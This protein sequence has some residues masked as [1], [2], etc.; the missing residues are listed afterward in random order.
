MDYVLCLYVG[1]LLLLLGYF[2]FCS[3][4]HNFPRNLPFGMP[5]GPF[6]R[7]LSKKSKLYWRA[8]GYVSATWQSVNCTYAVIAI[9]AKTNRYLWKLSI[10]IAAI[11]DDED[12]DDDIMKSNVYLFCS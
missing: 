10:A 8:G 6:V 11:D 2:S 7:E 5:Q 12:D 9:N 4:L 3:I 1:L